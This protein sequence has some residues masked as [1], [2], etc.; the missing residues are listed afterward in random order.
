MNQQCT[1]RSGRVGGLTRGVEFLFKKNKVEWIRGAARIA[2]R[3]RIEVTDGPDGNDAQRLSARE[4]VIATG[5]TP[6]SVPGV[7]ID[8]R[9]II[10][11]DEAIGLREVPKTIVILGSG[12]VGVEFASIF[13]R[14]GSQV[15]L[16]ELLPRLVP[17]ED[18]AISAE[19]LKSFRKQ[20]VTAS[21]RHESHEG[22]RSASPRRGRGAV[23]G[24][25]VGAIERRLSARGDRSS[26]PPAGLGA[27][28]S[29]LRPRSRVHHGRSIVPARV[30]RDFRPSATSS[31]SAAAVR[32]SWRTCHRLKG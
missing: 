24:W 21:H 28:G 1:E 12:A 27:T 32:T 11:S 30:F 16:I 13:G 2:D 10:T 23:A 9:R 25:K 5:S 3:G 4:I 7:E 15:T 20:G 18:E 31:P 26:P 22:D 6:R 14:F 17:A 19:L 29:G 8:R